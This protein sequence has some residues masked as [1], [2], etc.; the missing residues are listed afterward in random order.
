M[1][2]RIQQR[3]HTETLQTINGCDSVVTLNLT[4][5]NSP[6]FSLTDDTL[7]VCSEDSIQLDAGLGYASH[8]WSNGANTPQTYAASNGFY[9]ATVTDANGCSASDS[10]LVDILNVSIAQNDTTICEGDSLCCWL[11]ALK[12]LNIFSGNLNNGLLAYYPFNGNANDESGNG[13]TGT[14]KSSNTNY[15]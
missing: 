9:T 5:N 2:I 8:A 14:V 12:N 3:D 6:S 10:V 4:I 11:M 7:C 1:A 13:N 15:W